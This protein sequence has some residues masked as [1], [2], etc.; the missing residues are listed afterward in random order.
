MHFGYIG[1]TTHGFPRS[2][3]V[4]YRDVGTPDAVIMSLSGHTSLDIYRDYRVSDLKVQ[5]EASTKGGSEK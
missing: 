1:M 5:R 3:I 4:Y 2:A